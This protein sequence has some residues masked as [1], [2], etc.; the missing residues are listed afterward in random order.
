MGKLRGSRGST[1]SRVHGGKISG[2]FGVMRDLSANW[3]KSSKWYQRSNAI[4]FSW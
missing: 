1:F 4:S 3:V 2:L